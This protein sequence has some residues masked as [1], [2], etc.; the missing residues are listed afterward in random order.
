MGFN[1]VMLAGYLVT[2][3]VTAKFGLP[4]SSVAAGLG[5]SLAVVR[6]D[7]LRVEA[8]VGGATDI[9]L[10]EENRSED[11]SD[12]SSDDEQVRRVVKLA[13]VRE[14]RSQIADGWPVRSD[15]QRG[16]VP[17]LQSSVLT[18]LGHA[19]PLRSVATTTIE[20][21]RGASCWTAMPETQPT[22]ASVILSALHPERPAVALL[23]AA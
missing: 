22:V 16:P 9:D 3:M 21:F 18:A 12:G 14:R 23:R 17:V 20:L 11:T 5:V 6:A 4:W 13:D 15:E 19:E 7:R 2:A 10:D 8:S 1:M